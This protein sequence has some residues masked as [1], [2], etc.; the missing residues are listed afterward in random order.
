[1]SKSFLAKVA[2]VAATVLAL[3]SCVALG[4][5]SNAAMTASFKTIG[6]YQAQKVDWKSCGTDLYCGS[7]RVPMDY[8][9]LGSKKITLAVIYHRASANKPLG[10]LLVNP[11]GPGASGFNF[12]KDSIDGLATARLRANYNIVG[13]DP[14]GV[15]NSAAV[16]CLTGKSMDRFLYGTTGYELGS[17]KD[18]AK[19][20]LVMANFIKACKKNTGDLLGHVDTVSAA[21]DMDIIRAVM[22]DDKLNYL[23]FSYGTQLGATYAALFPKK[24]GRM[25]LDGAIDPSVPD[26]QQSLNQIKGFDLALR[27]YMTDCLS[28]SGCPFTGKVEDGLA[29]IR[30]FLKQVEDKPLTS[31]DNHREVSIW[32]ANTGIIMALYSEDYWQYLTAAFKAAFAGDGTTLLRLADFYN[33]RDPDGTYTSNLTEANIAISCL[34]S[35]Q[36]SKLSSMKAQNARML[37][38]SP[39]LGRYWQ[40]GGIGCAKWPYPVAKAPKSYAAKG[41]PT[42][43]VVGTTGDPATPYE[44]AVSLAHKILNKGFLVTY[45]GE[46]HTAYGRSNSCV[47]NA[48]DNFFID[49]KLAT[50]EPVC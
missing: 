3:T 20:K 25:V 28:K 33:D 39:T 49:G 4:T 22:G 35:R 32:A 15:Q 14:R 1:M 41:A 30:A 2:A 45:K 11:G 6:D 21:K 9:K 13:F 47:D 27:D 7:V 43:V 36:S 24:V 16:R 10:S 5:A 34:D 12:V 42:I 17:A 18:L 48:V 8:S 46:G 19:T 44:Q 31:T 50:T 29:K 23:G 38:A 40:W 37:K 26:Y